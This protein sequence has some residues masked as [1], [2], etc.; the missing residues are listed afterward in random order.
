MHFED[1]HLFRPKPTRLQRNYQEYEIGLVNQ[2]Y[3]DKKTFS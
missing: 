3:A 1:M 2:A